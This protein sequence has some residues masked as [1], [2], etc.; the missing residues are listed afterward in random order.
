MKCLTKAVGTIVFILLFANVAFVSRAADITINE[1]KTLEWG[2]NGN[3]D[4]N[5][6]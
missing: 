4:I 6:N 3:V 1:A 5:D 2:K